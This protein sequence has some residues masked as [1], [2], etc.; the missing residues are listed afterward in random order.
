MCVIIYKPAG[1]VLPA[2]RIIEAAATVNHDGC[3]LCTPQSMVKSL[4]FDEFRMYLNMVK[5]TEPCLIH[6]RWATNGSIR[7]SKLSPF[8]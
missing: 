4:D 1:M 5:R 6:F 8:L 3:G 2:E 7:Q